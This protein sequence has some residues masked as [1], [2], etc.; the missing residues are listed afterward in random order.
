MIARVLAHPAQTLRETHRHLPHRPRGRGADRRADRAPLGRPPRPRDAHPRRPRRPARLRADRR[1][2]AATSCSA[3]ARTSAADGK[4]R[5]QRAVPLTTDA[6][7]VLAVWLAERAGRPDDPLFPTRTGRR[8]SR[9]AVEQR[10]STHAATAASAAASLHDQAPAPARAPAQLRDVAAASRR[11][12]HRHRALAR[13]RRRPLHP[14][15]PP[16]RPDH[17]RERAL[18]LVTPPTVAPGRYKPTDDVLAF[19]DSL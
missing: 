8:L 19:L 15:L 16:R 9:D 6:Q 17:Q 13:T 12:H 10:V 5:K 1:S 7:A 3:P 18:A 2:T 11:R 14:A 4:G